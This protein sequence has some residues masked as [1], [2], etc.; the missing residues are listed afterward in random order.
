MVNQWDVTCGTCEW[1]GKV[2]W[3]MLSCV[4]KCPDCNSRKLKAR[5]IRPVII[6]KPVADTSNDQMGNLW[7]VLVGP[8]P[9]EL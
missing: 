7:R 2:E 8:A 4:Y 3:G 6:S 9:N 5:Y 1:T